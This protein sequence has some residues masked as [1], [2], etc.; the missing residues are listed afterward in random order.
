MVSSNDARDEHGSDILRVWHLVREGLFRERKKVAHHFTR[1][2]ARDRSDQIGINFRA[3]RA[4]IAFHRW[5]HGGD[6]EDDDLDVAQ[7]NPRLKT[8]CQVVARAEP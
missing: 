5:P 4:E 3:Q 8:S 1:R 6:R 7:G 2:S